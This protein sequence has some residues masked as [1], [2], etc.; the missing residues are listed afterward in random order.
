MCSNR[1]DGNTML[2]RHVPQYGHVA[3]GLGTVNRN[4]WDTKKCEVLLV[5]EKKSLMLDATG[6]SDTESQRQ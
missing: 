2:L 4:Q 1:S 5:L 6:H 3:V